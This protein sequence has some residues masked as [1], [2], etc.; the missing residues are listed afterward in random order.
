MADLI[1][2]EE[3]ILQILRSLPLF[4]RHFLNIRTK[5]GIVAPFELN[6]AQIFLHEKLEAQLR[7]VGIVRAI[8]LKGRQGGCSTYVQARFFHKVCTQV[9]KKAFILTHEAEATKNLFDMTKRYCDL[10]EPGVI[11]SP[12]TNSAKHLNF[13]ALNSE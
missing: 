5:A 13:K 2:N 1:V 10:M 9:G 12:D 8:I 6:R 4:A 11:P 7:D 3:K